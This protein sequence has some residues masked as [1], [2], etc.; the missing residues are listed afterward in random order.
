MKNMKKLLQKAMVFTLTAA[1]LIGTPLSASAA[2]LV[3]LY[4]VEDGWGNVIEQDGPN[5]TRTGTVTATQTNSG[6]LNANPTLM[7]IVLDETNY[8]IELPKSAGAKPDTLT[9]SF[10]WG[11]EKLDEKTQKLNDELLKHLKWSVEGTGGKK[12]TDILALEGKFYGAKRD[13]ITLK[14]KAAGTAKVTVSLDSAEYNLHYSAVATVTVVQY[15]DVLKFGD[16]L[17]TYAV[18][19]NVI[20]LNE[21]VETY[22]MKDGKEVKEDTSDTITYALKADSKAATLKNSMLTL[23]QEGSIQLMAIGKK[24]TSGWT[25]ITVGKGHN[26]KKIEFTGGNK[27][28]WVINDGMTL[29]VEAVVTE[30]KD[31]E[32]PCTDKIS[33][34]SKKPAIV[35]V[36]TTAPMKLT[37][38]KCQVT[39]IPKAV[40]KAQIVAKA[41]SGKSATLNVTVSA[42]LTKIK[43]EEAKGK[44][45]E[46][47]ITYYSGQTVDLYELADQYFENKGEM[48][49][50]DAGLKWIFDGDSSEQKPMKKVASLNAKGILNIKP[51]ITSVSGGTDV[52]RVLAVNAKKVGDKK[53]GEIKSEVLKI[54][55]EQVN[56]T[57]ITVKKGKDPVASATASNGKVTQKVKG[58]TNT[59]TVVA[60]ASRVYTLTARGTIGK[61]EKIVELDRSVLGWTASGNGKIV[62]AS[63]N[64]SDNGVISAIKKG[65]AT[66]T[67]NSATKKNDKYV[68]I[69]TTFKAKVTAPTKTLSLS[70]KNRGIAATG[71]KQTISITPVIEKGTTTNKNKDI[72][73]EAWK[74]GN[75]ISIDK[76]KIKNIILDEKDLG[77]EIKV[78]ATVLNG[79]P[80]TTIRLTVV[81]PSKNV[82][83]QNGET[84]TSKEELTEN[85]DSKTVN[86]KVNLA[87]G[88][89]GV[90]DKENVSG[91]TYT[92]NKA[93][94]VRVVDNKDGT[95]TIEPLVKGSVKITATTLDGKKGSLNVKVK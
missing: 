80:K 74:N 94:I 33:W 13:T 19:G 6:V 91:V 75:K 41:S 95:I 87:A 67:V 46:A 54:K 4:K 61:S 9:A 72:K 15:A 11:T 82:E 89:A 70:V 76:G 3:D 55:L 92:V 14:P 37:D 84:K 5:D 32:N 40:G 29:D 27:V 49:F 79:G 26:A 31:G 69:K 12:G 24:K 22:V 10:D 93:G 85:G 86:V 65:T 71:R 66:I 52:I 51:D 56:V 77:A 50:T 7:G 47:D 59:D 78:T 25:T 73:W 34:S 90:P 43:I 35:E 23:K 18:T 83:F 81:K 17:A 20:D 63:R 44:E 68:A 45:D 21:Y 62:K 58:A 38:N 53:P 8:E 60:G 1:M 57:E 88:G 30:T 48:N 36:K 28:T 16:D 39:L 2:G 42:N 64:K